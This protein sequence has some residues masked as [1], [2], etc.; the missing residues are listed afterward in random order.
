MTQS[1][2]G[3]PLLKVNY[4]EKDIARLEFSTVARRASSSDLKSLWVEDFI[5]DSYIISKNYDN[6]LIISYDNFMMAF[7]NESF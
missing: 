2:L 3:N 5:S 1:L 4:R 6:I 7:F